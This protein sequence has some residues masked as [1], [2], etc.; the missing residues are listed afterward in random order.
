MPPPHGGPLFS[1]TLFVFAKQMVQV[2]ASRPAVS[3]HQPPSSWNVGSNYTNISPSYLRHLKINLC[4][5]HTFADMG[6]QTNRR[7]IYNQWDD[8]YQ[9]LAK[10]AFQIGTGILKQYIPYLHCFF[11]WLRFSLL[12]MSLIM[13]ISSITFLL[14][15]TLSTQ[16][17]PTL[18]C[19]CSI[20]VYL[21]FRSML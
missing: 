3:T 12:S 5:F 7:K 19:K 15:Y 17:L 4:I 20:Y 18:I 13:L 9:E 16:N 11:H 8:G 14:Y 2:N 6:L 10:H 21:T 1:K